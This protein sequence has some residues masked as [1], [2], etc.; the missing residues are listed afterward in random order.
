MHRSPHSAGG[1]LRR[2]AG[3]TATTGTLA[4]VFLSSLLTAAPAD[5]VGATAPKPIRP[6]EAY[7]GSQI[8]RHEGRSAQ[9]SALTVRGG[10]EGVDVSAH[11]RNASWPSLRRKGVRFAYIKA[12]ESTRYKSP[13]FARQ[14]NGAYRAGI[15]RGAYHFAVP[16]ASSGQAQARFFLSHGGGWSKDGKTL[17]GALDLEYNPYGSSC[18]GLSHAR[19]VSWIRGFVTAYRART[20]RDAVIYTSTRW[21]RQCTGNYRGFA[22]AHPLWVPHYG[23]SV[24]ALPAGWRVHTIWQYTSKGTGVGDHNRFNGAQAR[25]RALANG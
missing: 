12:T 2:R 22:A 18:Y 23:S 16:N 14:Y 7:A 5:A 25:L 13:A 11:Q 9:S 19:M 20:R 15:V 10:T 17:P 21:W 4:T 1:P 6:G 24:G 8:L 3:L